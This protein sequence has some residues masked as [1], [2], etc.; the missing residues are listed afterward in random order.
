MYKLLIDTDGM[1]VTKRPRSIVI[2]QIG[3]KLLG[4]YKSGRG[5]NED[6]SS[7]GKFYDE[8][9]IVL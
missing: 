9:S 7:I 2:I 6:L 8:L 4:W 1:D 5:L 3:G